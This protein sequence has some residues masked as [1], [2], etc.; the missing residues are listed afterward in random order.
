[1]DRLRD[2]VNSCL[3]TRVNFVRTTFLF[4][5]LDF[6]FIGKVELLLHFLITNIRHLKEGVQVNKI[7]IMTF[8]SIYP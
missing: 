3:V 8:W 1:M 7:Y 6:S 2:F 4:P 5:S